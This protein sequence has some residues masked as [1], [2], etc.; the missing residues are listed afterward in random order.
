VR[1]GELTAHAISTLQLLRDAFGVVF[2]LKEDKQLM[3]VTKP[4]SAKK[5]QLV[6][7]DDADEDEN[8]E[9]EESEEEMELDSEVAT[10]NGTDDE[11]ARSEHEND[12]TQQKSNADPSCDIESY[13]HTTVLLSCLGTG[14]VNVNRRVT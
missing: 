3:K 8:E 7:S 11:Q 4:H 14:F 12:A 6:K 9:D 10:E 1:F 5:V 2:K 13:Y